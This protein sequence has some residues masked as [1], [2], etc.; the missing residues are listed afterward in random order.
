MLNFRVLFEQSILK[1]NLAESIREVL[2]DRKAVS[3]Y[4][5]GTLK[6]VQQTAQYGEKRK[7]L[8]PP[9]M[10]LDFKE[11]SSTNSDLINW[12]KAKYGINKSDAEAAV[13][14]FSEKVLN[15]L[16]NTQ[17]VK[18]P[19]VAYFEKSQGNGLTCEADPGLLSAF[20][21]GFPEVKLD[22]PVVEKEETQI[23]IS[24]LK[25]ED[26]VDSVVDTSHD[27]D[28]DSTDIDLAKEETMDADMDS[29]EAGLISNLSGDAEI[30]EKEQSEEVPE[31]ESEPMNL[32]DKFKY[33]HQKESSTSGDEE[34][35]VQEVFDLKS[36][37]ENLDEKDQ[38]AAFEKIVEEAEAINEQKRSKRMNS[39][40]GTLLILFSIALACV[41]IVDACKKYNKNK[42]I[43]TDTVLNEP[44]LANADGADAAAQEML[45]TEPP[46]PVIEKC[47][48][49]T[50][51]FSTEPNI[52][53]M[54]DLITKAGY[55]SYSEKN[56]VYTRVGLEF[57]CT[58][59]NLEEYIQQVRKSI[60][61][62]AWYLNPELYVAYK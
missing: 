22:I 55:T 34:E 21:A 53:K 42:S 25:E 37:L 35:Q 36:E 8:L 57:D 41:L 26:T 50:G 3:L 4:G 49:V 43:Q 54:K 12:L 59:V 2:M 39:M 38:F 58:D 61:P 44:D 45:N 11:S 10:I 51:V 32:N 46:T 52:N 1:L 19:G 56:G 15:V 17:S 23:A 40:W 60:S 28:P 33:L 18:I 13:K 29:E 16:L 9:S 20:Y 5:L 30:P 48:I 7:T 62:R 47:I 27:L 6:L 24:D 31:E 14:Q